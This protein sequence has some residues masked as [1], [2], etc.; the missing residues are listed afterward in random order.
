MTDHPTTPSWAVPGARVV[1]IGPFS[2]PDFFN[3]ERVP[4][5]NEVYTLRD[6]AVAMG[7]IGCRLKEF[8]NPPCMTVAGYLE[9]FYVLSAFR[10]AVAQK[11][12][13]EDVALFERI[14]HGTTILERL[15]LIAADLNARQTTIEPD[16]AEVVYANR[17]KLYW[18]G[19]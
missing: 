10:P 13:Q 15:D 17:S 9:R 3:G 18:T 19:R 8:V 6:V 7:E 14:A 16:I 12:E 1:C 11:T 5:V 4:K 2:Q